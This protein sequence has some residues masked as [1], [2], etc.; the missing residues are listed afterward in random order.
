MPIRFEVYHDEV[1]GIR[2]VFKRDTDDPEVL[3]IY[4]RHLTTVEEAIST[5]FAGQTVF[6]EQRKRFETFSSTHGLFWFWLK[7]GTEVMVITCFRNEGST[8]TSA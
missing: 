4:A 3:H 5:F 1:S 6:N 8:W 7:Q 2:F